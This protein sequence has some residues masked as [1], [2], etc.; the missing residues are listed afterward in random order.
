MPHFSIKQKLLYFSAFYCV[1]IAIIMIT[2]GFF[3][4]QV[5]KSYLSKENVYQLVRFTQNARIEQKAYLQYHKEAHIQQLSSAFADMLSSLKNLHSTEEKV[6]KFKEDI[7]TYQKTFDNVVETHRTL[8]KT[9]QQ[10]DLYVKRIKDFTYQ[11]FKGIVTEELKLRMSG[12]P[13]PNES[14]GLKMAVSRSLNAI[15]ELCNLYQRF[16]IEGQPTY[17]DE[18]NTLVQE[19]IDDHLVP[20]RNFAKNP[21][22]AAY[23][24]IAQSIEEAFQLCKAIPEISKNAFASQS[25]SIQMLD[26][27]DSRIS[28]NADALLAE[29]NT[30]NDAS[31]T[32]AF[33]FFALMTI[34]GIGLAVTLGIVTNGMISEALQS[35]LQATKTLCV[36]DLTTRFRVVSQDEVGITARQ[37]NAFVESFQVIVRDFEENAH[38]IHSASS[39]LQECANDLHSDIK[40]MELLATEMAQLSQSA[41]PQDRTQSIQF[42]TDVADK[43]LKIAQEIHLTAS[44]AVKHDFSF[45]EISEN[46]ISVSANLRKKI[47]QFKI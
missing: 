47:R 37:L 28:F 8:L 12:V 4:H 42:P 22:N 25:K 14:I 9:R 29:A 44:Q 39:E 11:I 32:T 45:A 6:K 2:I 17:L 46:L 31:K 5:E 40:A 35:F 13:I 24:A 41:P 21:K 34:V 19:R 36:G 10:L 7:A 30:H 26:K 33:I 43:I 1:L 15:L 38:T 20:L 3:S 23:K 18:F 16:L 27:I